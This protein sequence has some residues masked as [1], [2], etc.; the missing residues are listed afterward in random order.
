M[1]F[2]HG[3]QDRVVPYRSGRRAFE[4]VLWPKAFVALLG[5]GHIDPYLRPGD[6]AFDVVAKT[7]SEFLSWTLGDQ[8]ALQ[9]PASRWRHG[10]GLS[11][12]DDAL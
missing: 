6:P 9:A 1:L 2:E 5:H 10:R 7:A 8:Q 3:D 12:F 4:A 11:R